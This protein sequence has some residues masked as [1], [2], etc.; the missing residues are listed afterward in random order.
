MVIDETAG[1]ELRVRYAVVTEVRRGAG[2]E[3]A[4]ART[5]FHCRKRAGGL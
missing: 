4:V 5:A 2:D 3:P 1:R